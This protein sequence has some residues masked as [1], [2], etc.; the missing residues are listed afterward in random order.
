MPEPNEINVMMEFFKGEDVPVFEPIRLNPPADSNYIIDDSIFDEPVD[1]VAASVARRSEPTFLRVLHAYPG[2]S[3]ID[4][5]YIKDGEKKILL[6]E[7]LGICRLTG[8]KK[9]M[10]GLAQINIYPSYRK[11]PLDSFHIDL[12][13]RG[14]YYTLMLGGYSQELK[15]LISYDMKKA[16]EGKAC[17]R[18]INL[19]PDLG[20]VD[21]MLDNRTIFP[22]V[23]EGTI[24]NYI[25][26][27]PDIY[28]IKL[29][30]SRTREFLL[31]GKKAIFQQNR[32]Y[33]VYVLGF[34]R[35]YPGL[36]M[37]ISQDGD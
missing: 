32:A 16:P 33:T 13:A 6:A 17:I 3:R 27:K 22:A 4:L 10:D 34:V 24:T 30:S 8:Y 11:N 7:N 25:E 9:V 14:G 5:L 29:I 21:L 12:P 31:A 26:I 20:P 35:G 2:A 15:P 18:L 23:K 28:N 1:A 36:S 19:S 37:A